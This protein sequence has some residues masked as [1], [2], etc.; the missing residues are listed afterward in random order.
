MGLQVDQ[1]VSA[2]T[3]AG[4]GLAGTVWGDIQTYAIPELQKIAA[5]VV[6]IETGM[7]L[8]PP[9]YTPDGAAALL[10]MQVQASIGVIV[11]MTTLTLLAVQTAIN[12][13]LDA[14]KGMVNTA[15]KFPLIA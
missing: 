15:L 8:N 13:I 14:I 11:A 5:Q 3:S 2:M 4:E 6:A 1:L 10:D 9:Q 12:Q 7:L